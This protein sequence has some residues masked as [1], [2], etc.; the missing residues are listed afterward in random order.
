M[1]KPYLDDPTRPPPIPMEYAGMWVAVDPTG[2]RILAAGKSLDE[3]ANAAQAAGHSEY[4]LD[5]GPDRLGRQMVG[6]WSTRR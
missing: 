3:A 1:K 4:V 6:G 2:W 5:K